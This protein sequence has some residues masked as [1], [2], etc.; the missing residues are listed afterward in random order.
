MPAKAMPAAPEM[1]ATTV[2]A[3]AATSVKPAAAAAMASGRRRGR[4]DDNRARQ[5]SRARQ[6]H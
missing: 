1:A 4:T 2:E 5:N 3:T 6:R